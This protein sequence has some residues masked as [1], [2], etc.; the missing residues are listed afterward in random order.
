MYVCM[1]VC[2]CVCVCMYVCMCMYVC[3]C[4]YVCMYVCMLWSLSGYLMAI[5]VYMVS[6]SESF[7]VA[8]M[9]LM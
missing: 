5:K 6:G 4:M 3:V 8:A 7:L 1:Y 2:V 9:V